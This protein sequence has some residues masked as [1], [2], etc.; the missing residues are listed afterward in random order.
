M[1]NITTTGIVGSVSFADLGDRTFIHPTVDYDLES[2]YSLF[3]LL[4]SEDIQ[5]SI[6][7]GHITVANQDNEI[8]DLDSYLL[9]RDS[10]TAYTVRT[11]DELLDIHRTSDRDWETV[12]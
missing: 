11:V 8:T 6:D 4:A 7:N 5:A 12:I 3:R 9:R 10:N 1:F 2:E